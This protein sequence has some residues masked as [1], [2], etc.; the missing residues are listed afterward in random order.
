LPPGGRR[1]LFEPFWR[2]DGAPAGGTGL[3][4]AIVERLQRAQDGEVSV[5]SPAEGG[6]EFILTYRSAD[7]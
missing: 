7:G 4:L 5:R 6:A 2:G 1:K 3:G